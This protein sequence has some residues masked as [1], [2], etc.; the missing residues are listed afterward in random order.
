MR[1]YAKI[2]D[3]DTHFKIHAKLYLKKYEKLARK[4]LVEISEVD[5]LPYDV[6]LTDYGDEI[7]SEIKTLE[8]EWT[9]IADCNIEELR[10]IAINTFE[11]SYN[12]KKNQ[13]Y[14]KK[15]ILNRGE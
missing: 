13:K 14:Q 9:E 3:D 12:F 2:Q 6:T 5:D 15:I 7:L 11:I 10:K 1:H 4:N 8:K